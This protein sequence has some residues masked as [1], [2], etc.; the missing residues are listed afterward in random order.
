MR[1]KLRLICN[2]AACRRIASRKP[3]HYPKT[4]VFLCMTDK[5]ANLCLF[6]CLFSFPLGFAWYYNFPCGVDTEK[7]CFAHIQT[8]L[9]YFLKGTVNNFSCSLL[10]LFMSLFFLH[11]DHN[12]CPFPWFFPLSLSRSNFVS[13]LLLLD[14]AGKRGWG[15]GGVHVE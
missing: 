13:S 11:S 14:V 12:C 2:A 5:H 3:V 8:I 1:S 7:S 10:F 15:E 9:Y 4:A 6:P